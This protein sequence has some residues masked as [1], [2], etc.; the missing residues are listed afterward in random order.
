MKK[1]TVLLMVIGLFVAK[2]SFA[3]NADLFNYDAKSIQSELTTLNV[4]DQFVEQNDVTYTDML[5]MD[6]PMASELSYGST[7]AF[8]I[9]MLEP[10]AGI[11]SIVWGFCCWLPGVAVVYFVTEDNEETKKA[12]YGCVAFTVIVVAWNVMWRMI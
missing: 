5:Q 10:V 7:G 12:A 11:P 6:S 3:G 8:G 2:S 4:V 1:I 9:Q